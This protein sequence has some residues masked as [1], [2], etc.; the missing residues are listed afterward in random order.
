[1]NILREN[2]AFRQYRAIGH[3]DK[4]GYSN[5]SIDIALISRERGKLYEFPAWLRTHV[6]VPFPRD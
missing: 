3:D 6:S 1:M 5:L 2:V 4:T